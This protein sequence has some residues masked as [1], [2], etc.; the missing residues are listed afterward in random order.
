[1]SAAADRAPKPSA[2]RHR[3][4][5]RLAAVQALYQIELA[6]APV[7]S[8]IGEFVHHR[9]GRDH[10]DMRFGDADPEFFAALVRGADA[11]REELDRLIVAALTPDWPLERLEAVLRAIL[12]A[13][14][15]ELVASVDVPGAVVISEYLDIGH[16][17]F[18][19][20]EPGMVNGVLDRMARSLRP[21][22]VAGERHGGAASR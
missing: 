18:A 5:A 9:I 2:G 22:E 19:G 7:D 6:G 10:E 12:R 11:Q 21:Q 15:Y 13:G 20:K 4:A 16:A 1:M 8:V 17:F 14:A 3:T